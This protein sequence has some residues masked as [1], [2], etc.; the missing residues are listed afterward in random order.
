[1][2]SE[3]A[4][5]LAIPSDGTYYP[6]L[7]IRKQNAELVGVGLRVWGWDDTKYVFTNKDGEPY[8]Y[9]KHA[10]VFPSNEKSSTR[11]LE[12]SFGYKDATA[13]EFSESISLYL[14]ADGSAAI[15]SN[16]WAMAY[17]ETGYEGHAGSSLHNLTD[18]DIAAFGD[19][20]AEIVG[21]TPMCVSAKIEQ[22][23]LELTDTAATPS[24]KQAICDLIEATWPAQASYLLNT[25]VDDEDQTLAQQLCD[26]TTADTTAEKVNAIT[27]EW[28]AR[29]QKRNSNT[30]RLA[31]FQL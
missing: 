21:D 22:Q 27:K 5:Q 2:L 25:L 31:L 18:D 4:E 7:D 29:R 14:S 23:L 19:L 11:Q 13:G 20:I 16:I 6:I 3:E 8:E 30:A 26:K 15:S 17:A 1:M 28:E 12:L 9:P 10:L 24:A